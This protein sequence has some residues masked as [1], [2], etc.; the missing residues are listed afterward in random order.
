MRMMSDRQ[1]GAGRDMPPR[2]EEILQRDGMLVAP[3]VG[4]SMWPMLRSRRDTVVVHATGADAAAPVPETGDVVLYRAGGQYVLH[5][6]VGR[7]PDGAWRVRG[8][9]TTADERVSAAQVMGIL[10]EWYRGDHR[11]NC[12]QSG[13]YRRYWRLWLAI[14][15]LRR[16]LMRTWRRTRHALGALIRFQYD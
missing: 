9:N 10:T 12:R 13:W 16:V 4:A 2:I 5:R 7:W 8:D 14:W 1:A 11:I 3:A 15:P 6:I